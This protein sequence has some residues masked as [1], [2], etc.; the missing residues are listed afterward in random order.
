MKLEAP[1]AALRLNRPAT[2]L[3]EARYYFGLPL[4]SGSVRWKVSREPVYPT[5]WGWFGWAP[6]SG[7]ASQT[8]AAGQATVAADGTFRFTFTPAG[9]ERGSPGTG[10][11]PAELTYRYRAEAEVLDEGG[12]TRSATRSFRL[13]LTA[14]E[15]QPQSEVG[16]FRAGQPAELTALRT[17]L[18]GAPR[19]GEASFRI[20]ALAPPPQTLMPADEPVR[21]AP[22][23]APPLTEG[24]RQRARWAQGAAYSPEATLR[25]WPD[26][27]GAEVARGTLTHDAQGR[28]KITWPNPAPGAYRVHYATKDDFGESYETTKEIVVAAEHTELR[29]PALLLAERGSVPVGGTARL[30]ALAGFAGQPIELE[31]YRAGKLTE[32]RELTAGKDATLIERPVREGDRG[33]FAVTLRMLRDH[34]WISFTQAIFVPW[35]DR[36]LALSFSTFRDRIRPG[37]TE[38]WTVTVRG[39]GGRVPA[40]GTVQ[41]LAYMYDRSLDLFGPH[42]PPDPSRLWPAFDQAAPETVSLGVAPS[43]LLSVFQGHPSAGWVHGDSLV[44]LTNA[45]SWGGFGL[46]GYGPGGG[47]VASVRPSAPHGRADVR[48]CPGQARGQA[49]ARERAARGARKAAPGER[50]GRRSGPA[51]PELRRDRL[52][53]AEPAFGAR[54]RGEPDLPGPG[55]GDQLERVGARL[56]PRPE[57][58]RDPP[59]DPE[60]EGP[61]GPALPPP[62]P[63]RGGPGRGE[64]G[65]ERRCRSRP[66][67]AADPRARRPRDQPERAR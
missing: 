61:D 42:E 4:S 3:G 40:A 20:V 36:A 64:G 43:R 10:G 37:E 9:D 24:D 52:L 6:P 49:R 30:L 58:G 19:A 31:I 32:R 16:F 51:A 13:G 50:R 35:D 11:A 21:A 65:G 45:G 67:R 62:L 63:A 38:T 39:P 25:N 12:E 26:A 44:A 33:G 48:R 1:E 54:R 53:E 2:L 22:G 59:R 14:I 41:L 18:A 8:V 57:R 23:S 46:H 15:A 56:D 34:Q 5:W 29:L 60:R 7:G 28:A 66:R 55:L 17:D 27:P 47:G